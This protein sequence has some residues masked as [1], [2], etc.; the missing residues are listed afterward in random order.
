M[1]SLDINQKIATSAPSKTATSDSKDE[2]KV[3][4]S[5]LLK[6][7]TKDTDNTTDKNS[8]IVDSNFLDVDIKTSKTTKE[9][10]T[11]SILIKDVTPDTKETIT[12]ETITKDI[13]KTAST[14][15]SFLTLL[16]N[17]DSIDVKP[18]ETKTKDVL[19][20]DL[21]P[22]TKETITKDLPK[23]VSTKESFLTLL[24]NNDSIDVKPKDVLTKD[25]A[26]NTKE[27]ITKDISKTASTKESFLTLLKNNDSIDVKPKETKPKDVLTK[28]VP[29]TTSTKDSFLTL[30][31]G[32]DLSPVEQKDN[33]TTTTIPTEITPTKDVKVLVSEAKEYLKNQIVQTDGYK[34]SE[35]KDLPKTLKGL[36]SLADKYD[37]NVSKITI[38]DVKS[39]NVS[40]KN[41][42]LNSTTQNLNAQKTKDSINNIST[43][44]LISNNKNTTNSDTKKEIKPLEQMLKFSQKDSVEPTKEIKSD[45][46]LKDTTKVQITNKTKVPE[47]TKEIQPNNRTQTTKLTEDV[48]Q[49]RDVNTSKETTQKVETNKVNYNS[50]TQTKSEIV[51]EQLVQPKDIND[52]T[53]KTK[54]TQTLESLLRGDSKVVTNSSIVN[55]NISPKTA[56]IVTPAQS[57]LTKGLESLLQ[58]DKTDDTQIS[59]L[60]GMTV[61]KA[62]SFE[63]KV[64]ESKQM[65]KYLSDDVKTA[66]D[67][68]KSPFTRIKLQLNPQKLGDVEVTMVQRG[69]DLHVNIGSNNNAINTLSMNINELKIQLSNSGINNATLNFNNTTQSDGSFQQSGSNQQ[70][71]QKAHKEYNYFDNKTESDEEIVSSLEIVVPNYA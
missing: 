4:F 64:N 59:K 70:E 47:S 24:K 55:S 11:K 18:K 43:I 44:D 33:L 23:T 7:F 67:D 41:S 21:A 5:D 26:P 48:K 54:T 37:V 63:V 31:K 2:P 25:L 1:V 68:Y 10:T 62:D 32:E 46:D 52:K 6:G 58:T 38:E 66:I 15:E 29:K 49:V 40:D 42:T 36:V 34:K 51:S 53:Q 35:V 39:V 13:P 28:D 50:N 30:L 71:Q 65:I 69:N 16:K 56:T 45:N 12:K 57:D 60:D 22:N 8:K 3:S 17:N 27:T 20:K 19:T 61:H 9:D 14:K